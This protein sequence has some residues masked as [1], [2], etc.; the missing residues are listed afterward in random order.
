VIRYLLLIALLVAGACLSAF[1]GTTTYTDA[2]AFAAATKNLQ[3]TTFDTLYGPAGYTYYG[4]QLIYDGITFDYTGAAG[5]LFVVSA[6]YGADYSVLGSPSV[7]TA[8]QAAVNS[9]LLTFAGQTAVGFTFNTY[10]PY[11]PQGPVLVLF[12]TG[13]SFLTDPG[14]APGG[15]FLG[16]TSTTPITWV[17]FETTAY[18]LELGI[19]QRGTASPAPEPSAV[20]LLGCGLLAF[21]RVAKRR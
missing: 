13:E 18:D 16:L 6:A 10:S 11:A 15:S 3:T 1:A 5:G 7:L 14:T 8:Q 21:L 12:S 9:L 20:L 2:G 4:Y 19:V 17:S